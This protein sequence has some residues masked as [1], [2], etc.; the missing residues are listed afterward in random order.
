MIKNLYIPQLVPVSVYLP[1]FSPGVQ[2]V[3]GIPTS[4]VV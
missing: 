1:V 2:G 3:L 4:M